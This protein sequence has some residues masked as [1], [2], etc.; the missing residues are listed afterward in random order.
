MNKLSSVFIIIAAVLWGMIGLFINKLYQYGF[1][2]LQVVSIRAICSAFMLVLYLLITNKGLLRIKLADVKYFIGTGIISFAFFNWCLFVA[3]KTTSLSVATILMYTA[4]AFVTIF[5]IILFKEKLNSKKLIS[6][7]LT[8]LGCVLVT[9]FFQSSANRVST[10]GILAGLGAGLGY[11]L[12]SI[13][14]KYAL[15]KYDPMTIPAYTFVF[16]A[17]GLI[18]LTDFKEII[19]TLSNTTA[20]YYAIALGLFSTVL[21]FIFYTKGLAKLES[22]KASLIA[23]LEPVVA[24]IIGFIVFKENITFSKVLGILFVITALIIIRE[25][26]DNTELEN[27]SELTNKSPM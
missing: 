11:A 8:F 1:E 15:E 20:L 25:K 10:I 18:P 13:F 17:I 16:A 22:S 2:P 6:L 9:G 4:P 23:T 27:N 14:G 26:T 5:S 24:S 12:Y 21:P 19:T 3:I 7:A